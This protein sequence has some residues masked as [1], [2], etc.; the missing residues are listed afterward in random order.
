MSPSYFD[1]VVAQ[2]RRNPCLSELCEF[3]QQPSRAHSQSRTVCMDMFEQPGPST[4]RE[5]LG[6]NFGVELRKPMN[7]PELL[8]PGHRG[9]ILIIEDISKSILEELGSFFDIDPWFFASYVHQTWRKTSTQS[10]A[11]CALPSRDKKQNFLSLH[12]HRIVALQ[13]KDTTLRSVTRNTNQQR[14]AVILP[15]LGGERIGLVQHSASVMLIAP[16]E[17]IWTGSL[18]EPSRGLY[19]G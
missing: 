18:S 19:S 14:K 5:I 11:N 13:Q 3:L 8:A 10:P 9:R 16:P 15:S 6:N 4:Q 1:R 17:Q 7:Q 2:R 12:Y